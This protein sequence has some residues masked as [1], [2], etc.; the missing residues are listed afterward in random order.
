MRMDCACRTAITVTVL[1]TVAS[2]QPASRAAD[3]ET[4]VRR[5]DSQLELLT[6]DWLVDRLANARFRLHSPIEREA[7]F[8][9]DKPWEGGQ[10][11]YVTLLQNG[12]QF[13]MYYRGG[14]DLVREYTCVAES[15][16][17]IHWTRPT[18]GLFECEGSKANNIIWTG[19]RKAYDESHNFSPFLDANP[20]APPEEQYKAVSLARRFP[21][22]ERQNEL[23]G[24]VS[25][26][27]VR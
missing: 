25:A 10:S 8:R 2:W 21:N 22:G 7:V 9:F 6:D 4:A 19:E 12:S 17:G 3:A 20:A 15:D 27:G 18:L 23:V 5:I 16:D 26:D 24:F 1:L 11:G 14:G 13:R